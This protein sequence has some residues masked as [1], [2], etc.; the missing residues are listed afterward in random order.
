[1]ENKV[2]QKPLAPVLHGFLLRESGRVPSSKIR[3]MKLFR[4]L[5]TKEIQ[6]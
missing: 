5:S 4:T 2:P 1:M 6:S 3:I